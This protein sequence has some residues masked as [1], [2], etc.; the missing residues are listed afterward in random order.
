MQ[1]FLK[2]IRDGKTS[3]AEPVEPNCKTKCTRTTGF[4]STSPQSVSH[5]HRYLDQ[6]MFRYYLLLV[7]VL[8]QHVRQHRH[9]QQVAKIENNI[10]I[11]LS[12]EN[13]DNY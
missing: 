12:P 2:T 4:K 13:G 7:V 9:H 3:K 1:M 10:P 8:N 6:I 5:L 11:N